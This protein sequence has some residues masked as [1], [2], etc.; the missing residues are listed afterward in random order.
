MQKPWGRK[1][2]PE[3]VYPLLLHWLKVQANCNGTWEALGHAGPAQEFKPGFATVSGS[4]FQAYSC[5]NIFPN[6]PFHPLVLLL[7]SEYLKF[8]LIINLN[9]KGIIILN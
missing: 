7:N 5:S 8:F 3:Q 9:V 1:T 4:C 6:L 2:A